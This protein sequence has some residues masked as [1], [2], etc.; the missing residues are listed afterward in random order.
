MSSWGGIR[1][2]N[3]MATSRFIEDLHRNSSVNDRLNLPKRKD[4]RQ[5]QW[6]AERRFEQDHVHALAEKHYELEQLH[7]NTRN[8]LNDS[9]A[10]IVQLEAQLSDL[11]KGNGASNSTYYDGGYDNRGKVPPSAPRGAEEWDVLP[12]E[13]RE[14]SR[15]ATFNDDPPSMGDGGGGQPNAPLESGSEPPGE[16]TANPPASEEGERVTNSE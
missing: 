11:M 8:A 12:G 10:Y 7:W 16:S 6:L 1:K 3:Q 15:D 9:E 2:P 13:S 5:Q 4:P 14:V